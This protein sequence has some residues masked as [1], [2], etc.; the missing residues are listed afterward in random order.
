LQKYSLTVNQMSILKTIPLLKV[1]AVSRNSNNTLN[2]IY[3]LVN[4]TLNMYI[5]QIEGFI[6][7]TK[8]YGLEPKLHQIQVFFI[9]TVNRFK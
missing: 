7:A 5:D 6:Y 9:C 2:L 8:D 1:E 4:Q 3:S